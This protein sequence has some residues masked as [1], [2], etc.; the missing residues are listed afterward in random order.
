MQAASGNW[1]IGVDGTSQGPFPF[2]TLSQAAA[3]GR[4][5][6][7]TLVWSPGMPD[8]ARA[9][10]VQGLFVPPPAPRVPTV[11]P[12]APRVP[13]V[14]LP[15]PRVPSVGPTEAVTT[16]DGVA[17]HGAGSD[18]ESESALQRL[19][20]DQSAGPWRRLLARWI[21]V[22]I[23]LV[24]TVFVV[25]VGLSF[26]SSELGMWFQ[27]PTNGQLFALIVAP[28]SFILDALIVYIFGNS[29]G[30]AILRVRV[31]RTTGEGLTFWQYAKRNFSVW[32]YGLAL[33]IPLFSIFTML[34]QA[35]QLKGMGATGYDVGRYRVDAA[36]LTP[37]RTV[38]IGVVILSL[39]AAYVY[40]SFQDQIDRHAFNAGQQWTNPITFAEVQVP[41]GWVPAA[42][43]NEQGQAV[44]TFTSPRENLIV[45][46]GKEDLSG[47]SGGAYAQ[48]FPYAVKAS[49]KLAPTSAQPPLNGRNRWTTSGYLVADFTQAV[50][51]TIV[52]H[53]KQMWR[54]VAVRLNSLN[55][56]TESYQVLQA[57]LFSSF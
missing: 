32:A 10:D 48:A 6:R 2:T 23:S 44:Y 37:L 25:A 11:P 56:D 24:P 54:T 41:A 35:R 53:D 30:K 14:P 42:Q 8:W 31:R 21:D 46:F 7:E 3:D 33:C 57:R 50:S 29:I 45:V 20:A 5:T 16:A 12:P 34:Y 9:G 40:F 51:V 39:L 19:V 28:L 4:L 22:W 15:A 27:N 38:S 1:Y 26:V 49:M 13:T 43:T 55:P 17:P 52:Q 36:E 18:A 47:I